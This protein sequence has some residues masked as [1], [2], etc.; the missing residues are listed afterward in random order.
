MGRNLEARILEFMFG[1][2]HVLSCLCSKVFMFVQ[3]A[4][5]SD[6]NVPAMEY[7]ERATE[8]VVKRR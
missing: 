7:S 3:D 8:P 1:R 4:R 6:G 2:V 5:V